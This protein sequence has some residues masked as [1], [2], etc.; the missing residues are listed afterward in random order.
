MN[1]TP[2]RRRWIL[3][4][5]LAPFLVIAIAR[6]VAHD[7]L[8]PLIWLSSVTAWVFLPAY[9]VLLRAIV[10]KR[11]GVVF[12]ASFVV[13]C[14]LAWVAPSLVGA[15][16][17]ARAAERPRLRVATANLLGVNQHPEALLDELVELRAD[18][19]VLEEVSPRWLA[20]LDD[21]RM[22]AAYPHRDLL[23]REDSFGIAVLTNRPL[24]RSEL[25]DLE[26]VPMVDA[27]V[28][29]EGTP[30]RVFG[31][32]TLPPVDGAYAAIWRQQLELLT[33]RARAV[34]GPLVVAG[35]LNATTHAA[36]FEALV[37]IGLR[38]VHDHLGRGLA[39]TWPNGLFSLPPLRLDHVLVSP[40]LVPLAVREG[41][42]EGSDHRP[43]VADLALDHSV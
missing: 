39:T 36:G 18:V 8:L 23:A 27:T 3:P 34:D 26:G 4:A 33:M 21:D 31:V 28:D 42:G 15:P 6:L 40:E 10:R 30:V 38:D 22:R 17:P 35:D 13:A 37:D 29:V 20:L 12:A 9:L 11:A 24:L 43:V 14:H 16:T 41:R 32:H 25:V 1:D 19:L 7:A 2:T 5:L